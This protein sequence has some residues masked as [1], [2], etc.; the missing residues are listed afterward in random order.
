MASVSKL[1][2]QPLSN[3]TIPIHLAALVLLRKSIKGGAW[4]PQDSERLVFNVLYQPKVLDLLHLVN[5]R[6][7]DLFQP[8]TSIFS[9]RALIWVQFETVHFF[10]QLI[11]S[12]ISYFKNALHNLVIELCITLEN[13]SK[14]SH[15][16]LLKSHADC[17][18]W[19]FAKTQKNYFIAQESFHYFG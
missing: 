12:L 16:Y 13:T 17:S 11:F 10:S 14:T 8:K 2:L 6:I 19:L 4:L 5:S 9:T 7:R 18:Y 15:N 3:N 1:S